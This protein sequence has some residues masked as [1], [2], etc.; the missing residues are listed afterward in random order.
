MTV[1]SVDKNTEALS[2]T[3]VAGFDAG[4][5][6]VWKIWEDP[7][8]LERWWGPPTV[9]ATF[10][11][12]DFTPGGK[13]AYYMTVPDGTRAHGWWQFTTINAPDHL[14]FDYGFADDQ[15]TPMGEH[16]AAHATVKLEPIGDRTRMTMSTRFDSEEQLQ[17]MSDMGM[18][19]GLREAIGQVDALLAEPANASL[20]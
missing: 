11:T 10:E 18:E 1:V 2:L 5:Q 13:A 20:Q 7:R 17:M 15:G 19:E 4:V 12:H 16:G 3:V 9:P 8:Q 6:R 14:E